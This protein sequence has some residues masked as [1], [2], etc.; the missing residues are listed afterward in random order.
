MYGRRPAGGPARPLILARDGPSSSQVNHDLTSQISAEY[1]P[2]TTDILRPILS[3][4]GLLILT[5]LS[6]RR[7]GLGQEIDY[8]LPAAL[9]EFRDGITKKVERE[10]VE[11]GKQI[12]DALEIYIPVVL[13]ILTQEPQA[14]QRQ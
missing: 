9:Q 2:A 11:A 10:L 1:R 14:G 5:D 3:V 13:N 8:F 12:H 6:L 7:N 4:G